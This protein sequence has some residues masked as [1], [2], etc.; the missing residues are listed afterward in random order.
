M[1][2]IIGLAGY[3]FSYAVGFIRH[4]C[5][6]ITFSSKSLRETSTGLFF[7]FLTISDAFYQLISIRDFIV[8]YLLVPT[9]PSA[10]I[11]RL[12][13]FIQNFA[14]ITSAWLLVLITIHRL[15]RARFPYRQARICTPR[16]AAYSTAIV[17]ICS[18]A[19][20]CHV[21]LPQFAY[22]NVKS[23][24]C[25]PLRSPATSYSIFY[26]NI[27]FLLQLI[28]TYF[29]PSCLMIIFVISIHC[30]IRLQRN[31]VVG[32]TRREKIQRQMLI[33]MLSSIVCFIICTI[34]YSINR[35]L[36]QRTGVTTSTIT[37]IA[38]L[39]AIFNMNYCLNFYI[40]CLTSKLLRQTFI[41][42]IKRLCI[43]CKRQ[44]QD[45]TS[46]V[47]PLQTIRN[48]SILVLAN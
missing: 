8:L 20:N 43:P 44:R 42:Q 3:A 18:I 11:Y 27:W 45:I 34:P 14:T 5:S 25:G 30:K 37:A 17:C 1:S 38:I 22:T 32:V 41:E 35:I 4:I 33:L 13:I 48:R 39:T 47:H 21:L 7:I 28:I 10:E 23:N 6:L 19:L 29:I 9:V 16:M 15:I 36:Y 2:L 24:S 26:F 46:T 40:H 31:L 12:R